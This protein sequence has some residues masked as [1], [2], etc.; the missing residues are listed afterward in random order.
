VTQYCLSVTPV[1]LCGSGGSD[2]GDGDV[3]SSN[4]PSTSHNSATNVEPPSPKKAKLLDEYDNTDE[5]LSDM[6]LSEQITKY[7]EM[8]YD[9]ASDNCFSFWE[10][11]RN[12][13]PKLYTLA[14]I[15]LAVTASSAPV[16]RV[17]S[18]SG[19]FYKP[20]RS[21]ISDDNL[22]RLTYLKCNSKLQ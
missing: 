3:L 20:N 19:L 4:T 8:R 14:M 22:S 11:K 21:R 5:I 17:F 1:Q 10:R 6:S 15:I 2:T 9:T 18:F 16:E 12:V 13:L 7:L